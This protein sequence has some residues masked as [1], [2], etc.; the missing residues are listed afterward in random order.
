MNIKILCFFIHAFPTCLLSQKKCQRNDSLFIYDNYI[1]F[2]HAWG[3]SDQL[4][5]A[6]PGAIKVTPTAIKVTPFDGVTLFHL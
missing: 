2:I 5:K 1:N 4:I 6:T 3:N